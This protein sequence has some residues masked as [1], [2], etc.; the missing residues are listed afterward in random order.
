M[1][2]E[3]KRGFGIGNYRGRIIFLGDGT[4]V[5]TDSDDTDMFDSEDKDL[6]SQVPKATEPDGSEEEGMTTQTTEQP[7]SADGSPSDAKTGSQPESKS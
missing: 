6:D 7:K 4:E 5:L 2:M 3:H 1:D